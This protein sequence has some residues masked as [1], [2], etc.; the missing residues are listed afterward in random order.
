MAAA[1]NAIVVGFNVHAN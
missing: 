1:S